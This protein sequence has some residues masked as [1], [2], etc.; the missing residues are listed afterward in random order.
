MGRDWLLR[1]WLAGMECLSR[2]FPVM[3]RLCTLLCLV[4]FVVGPVRDEVVF[5]CMH[6]SKF[7]VSDTWAPAPF[8]NE[9]ILAREGSGNREDGDERDE[10]G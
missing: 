1:G 2:L 9:T 10:G 6:A 3:M 5:G 4:V 8:V 7:W